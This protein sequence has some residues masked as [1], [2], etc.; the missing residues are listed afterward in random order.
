MYESHHESVVRQFTGDQHSRSMTQWGPPLSLSSG[1]GVGGPVGNL[2][3]T[4][5]PQ[6]F[7]N[8]MDLGTS[9]NSSPETLFIDHL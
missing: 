3:Y 7:R 8:K 5:F 9:K 1:G 6:G 2:P 4:V